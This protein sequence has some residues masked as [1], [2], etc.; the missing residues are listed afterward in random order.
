MPPKILRRLPFEI[1]SVEGLPY[2]VTL[3]ARR[4]SKSPF[5]MFEYSCFQFG[6]IRDKMRSGEPASR[7]GDCIAPAPLLHVSWVARRA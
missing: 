3:F 2:E 7:I 6:G 4:N 5:A 1:K